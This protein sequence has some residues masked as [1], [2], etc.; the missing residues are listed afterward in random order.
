MTISANDAQPLLRTS[1]R[2]AVEPLVE[3]SNLRIAFRARGLAEREVVHG[4][5][6]QLQRGEVL[7]IVG[8][9]GSGKSITARSLLGLAPQNAIVTADRLRIGGLDL[10]FASRRQLRELRG[11]EVGYVLQDALGSLDPLR[12]IKKE[13][14]EAVVNRR[15]LPREELLS[16][17]HRLLE[18]VGLDEPAR[19]AEQYSVQLSGGQRQRALL[20]SAISAGP[21][22]LIADE[23][24]SALD[25][26]VQVQVIELLTKLVRESSLALLLISH[27]LKT[28]A[29]IADRVLVLRAG[30]IVEQGSPG[31]ILT[32][33]R[34]DYTR[35]LV[36][37]IPGRLSHKATH[38]PSARTAETLAP[39]TAIG[40]D[41]DA[42]LTIR[43]ISKHYRVRGG[44]RRVLDNVSLELYQGR[45]LGLVGE[46]G[47]GKSTL[48]KIIT[49]LIRPDRGQVLLDGVDALV[50]EGQRAAY[51][52]LQLV[53][54]DPYAS[55]DPR[56][57]VQRI[58]A[59]PLDVLTSLSAS[60]K[61]R[62]AVEAL[63]QVNLAPSLLHTHPRELSGGQRQRLSIARALIS[64]P[65]VVVLD[66][67]VS[68][69]D[70][71]TQAQVLRLISTL[72]QQS[73]TTFLFISHDL[74]VVEE[75]SDDLVVLKNGGV[76]E[77]GPAERVFSAPEHEYTRSLVRA[78]RYWT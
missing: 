41:K 32:S 54:Q 58:L 27:D 44:H 71:I 7:A 2:P 9:S 4:I 20:A 64:E 8:E 33:P 56:Y 40:D 59:E 46:S 57:D 34:H 78:S 3:A 31:E 36:E 55:F 5:S 18:A 39:T 43:G 65:E 35:Q 45:T 13:V 14:S 17:V 74:D 16:R 47:S 37:A 72:Q 61:K 21:S 67:A 69:L 12:R 6:F 26:V 22:L 24:T 38:H 73:S 1:D 51:R 15:R 25:A 76:I 70:V 28:V 30:T 52:K 68:A 53:T 60:E 62:A 75:V 77:S 50:G 63:E 10:G 48:A 11:A 66:E 49:G 23:P 29:S 42:V 19:R